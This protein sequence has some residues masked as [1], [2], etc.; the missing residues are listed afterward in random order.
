MKTIAIALILL[1]TG[2]RTEQTDF[3]PTVTNKQVSDSLIIDLS[4]FKMIGDSVLIVYTKSNPDTFRSSLNYDNE[5]HSRYFVETYEY[6]GFNRKLN[7]HFIDYHDWEGLYLTILV[8]DSND[9]RYRLSS[10]PLFSSDGKHFIDFC[11]SCFPLGEDGISLN[12]LNNGNIEKVWS[13]Y[14]SDWYPDSIKWV[15]ES[16][17]SYYETYRDSIN[18]GIISKRVKKIRELSGDL[19]N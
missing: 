14:S 6:K 12:S 5:T 15:S 16:R 13:E 10:Y 11:D 4:R 9:I 3:T 1:L 17:F 2:C 18:S 8:H 7:F 19:V